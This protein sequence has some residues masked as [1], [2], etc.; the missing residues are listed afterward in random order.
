MGEKSR[1]KGFDRNVKGLCERPDLY[2][3]RKENRS[4]STREPEGVGLDCFLWCKTFT[5]ESNKLTF[6]AHISM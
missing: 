1:N 4:P 2:M 6:T 5:E 3:K